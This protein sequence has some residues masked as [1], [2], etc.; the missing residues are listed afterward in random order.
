MKPKTLSRGD[1]TRTQIFTPPHITHAMLDLLPPESFADDEQNFLEP[2]CGNGQMLEVLVERIYAAMLAKHGEKER[3]LADLCFRFHAIEL[4]EAL[5]VACRS[6]IFQMLWAMAQDCNRETL[7]RYLL[8]RLVQHSIECRDFFTFMDE[9]NA[10]SAVRGQSDGPAL[11]KV[12]G[13]T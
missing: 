9:L 13:V 4:D 7:C 12:S 6:R 5:V 10:V 11:R 2:C 3:A 1:L 8:E